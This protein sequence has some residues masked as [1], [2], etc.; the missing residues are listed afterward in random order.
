MRTLAIGDIHGY[1]DVLRRLLAAVQVQPDDEVITVGD[2]VD[3]GPD[4][5]GVIDELLVLQRKGQLVPLRGNHDVMMLEARKG[6][7]QLREWITCGGDTTLASYG[8][9]IREGRLENVPERHWK[10]L[11]EDCVDWYETDTHIFVHANF[12]P[13]VEM[14]EQPLFLLHWEPLFE[15]RAHCSGKVVVCGHTKQRSGLPRNWGH[16]VCID[17]WVYGEGWLT[18][19]DVATQRIWQANRHGE[20]RVGRLPDSEEPHEHGET[21]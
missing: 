2:Y 17:T 16:T 5:R 20:L 4:S 15:A 7:E 3:R 11:E 10:F 12:A 6:K 1:A 13:D 14:G 18:C 8:D 21:K 9:S 19:L